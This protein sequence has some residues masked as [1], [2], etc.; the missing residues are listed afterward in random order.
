MT[1]K[2]TIKSLIDN[3]LHSQE[4]FFQFIR[5]GFVGGVSFVVDYGIMILLTELFGINPLW[6]AAISFI[7]GLTVNYLLSNLIVF[8]AHN[9][10]N[11]WAEFIIFAIIGVIGLGLNEL[12]MYICTAKL[13]IDYKIAKLISTVLVFCW[14]F[15]VR[16]I[17]LFSNT[18]KEIKK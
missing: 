14:N 16:K 6:S 9:L 18:K 2:F 10:K 17:A 7:A 4:T 15:F 11:R 12:I 13:L 8:S 5:Y 1:Q 3:T